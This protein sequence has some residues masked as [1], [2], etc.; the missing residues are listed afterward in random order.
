M[1]TLNTAFNNYLTGMEESKAIIKM[2][3][4]I[5]M[6]GDKI[7]LDDLFYYGFDGE[8]DKNGE[9]VYPKKNIDWVLV[10]KSYEGDTECIVYSIDGHQLN[11]RIVDRQVISIVYLKLQDYIKEFEK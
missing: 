10:Q 6:V 7:Y 8:V 3:K 9:N 4:D 2:V 11:N 1:G 5:N